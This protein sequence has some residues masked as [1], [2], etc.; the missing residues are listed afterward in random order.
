[1]HILVL[2]GTWAMM[3]VLSNISLTLK[4]INSKTKR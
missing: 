3:K 1:M 2:L 4:D